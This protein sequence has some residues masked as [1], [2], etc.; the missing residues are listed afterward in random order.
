MFWM[1]HALGRQWPYLRLGRERTVIVRA[2][3]ALSI[4]PPR[5]IIETV[6]TRGQTFRNWLFEF[7]L[8]RVPVQQAHFYA[9]ALQT[10][11]EDGEI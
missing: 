8:F 5:T 6:F 9:R 4:C 11:F 2:L 3:E 7:E 1:A 10:F